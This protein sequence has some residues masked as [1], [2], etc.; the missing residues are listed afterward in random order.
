MRRRRTARD[1]WANNL[2]DD[3]GEDA[4]Q[5]Y[6]YRDDPPRPRQ[7]LGFFYPEFFRLADV[8][9]QFGGGD[10]WYKAVRQG[11]VVR[12]G[13]FSIEG[14]PIPAPASPTR[15]SQPGQGPCPYCHRR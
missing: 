4:P 10:Y 15:P 12:S 14:P 1:N 8:A 2:P 11:R 13:G 6:L 5:V 7:Y 9:S 3:W